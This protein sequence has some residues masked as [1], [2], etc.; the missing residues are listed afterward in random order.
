M[1]IIRRNMALDMNASLA[2]ATTQVAICSATARIAEIRTLNV[3]ESQASLTSIITH[4]VR[5]DDFS[6][7]YISVLMLI[8]ALKK[9]KS[10][11]LIRHTDTSH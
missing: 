4:T 11:T 6:C 1:A 10:F 8:C 7:I 5:V 9:K 2:M 3:E